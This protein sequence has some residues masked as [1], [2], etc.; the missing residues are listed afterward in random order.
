M[1]ISVLPEVSVKE[2]DPVEVVTDVVVMSVDLGDGEEWFAMELPGRAERHRRDIVQ[3]GPIWSGSVASG[4]VSENPFIQA[5]IVEPA[6][7]PW[8]RE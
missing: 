3:R 7:A 6:A 1:A 4:S 5:G 8:R 2:P